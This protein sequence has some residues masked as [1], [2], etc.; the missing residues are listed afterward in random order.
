MSSA[1]AEQAIADAERIK[2][3]AAMLAVLIPECLGQPPGA[4]R[5]A[6]ASSI[7]SY[8]G[9]DLRTG[10][11]LPQGSRG[12]TTAEKKR[13][14]EAQLTGQEVKKA[15]RGEHSPEA[16]HAAAQPAESS[17]AHDVELGGCTAEQ[18]VPTWWHDCLTKGCR[19]RKLKA[20]F[21]EPGPG[22]EL[23][24]NANYNRFDG[25]SKEWELCSNDGTETFTEKL[26]RAS[27]IGLAR[28]DGDVKESVKKMKSRAFDA[29]DIGLDKYDRKDRLGLVLSEMLGAVVAVSTSCHP[30]SHICKHCG[31]EF[32]LGP[33]PTMCTSDKHPLRRSSRDNVRAFCEC[34]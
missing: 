27:P 19:N 12:A 25:S 10:G 6:L 7:L 3:N 31:M 5:D 13:Q 32:H 16:K 18:P 17:S 2:A 8:G 20:V 21:F 34:C 1:A 22:S 26:I 23:R 4:A 24:K 28:M 30:T 33:A 9:P 29:S 15:K 11:G 14:S